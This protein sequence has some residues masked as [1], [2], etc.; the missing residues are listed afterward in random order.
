MVGSI[1]L[2]ANYLSSTLQGSYFCVHCLMKLG[3]TLSTLV[4]IFVLVYLYT[5]VHAEHCIVDWTVLYREFS[6]VI[7]MH[8]SHIGVGFSCISMKW[9]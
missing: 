8:C 2:H 5:S 4:I 1:T 3:R 6:T 7:S 9:A